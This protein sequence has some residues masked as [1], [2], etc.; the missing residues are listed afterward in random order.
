[1]LVCGPYDHREFREAVNLLRQRSR[2]TLCRD[3]QTAAAVLRVGFAPELLVVVVSHPGQWSSD[4]IDRLRRLCPLAPVVVL[5][6]S[7][8]E[9]ETRS[10]TP[11]PGVVR[12]YWH[13]AASQ[14]DRQLA[15]M[16]ENQRTPWSL[17]STS[18][19]DERLLAD[20]PY[21][22]A[23]A[24]AGCIPASAGSRA[25]PLLV[26]CSENRP[27]AEWLV[28]AAGRG[29]FACVTVS[30]RQPWSACGASPVLCDFDEIGTAEE[31]MLLGMVTSVHPAPVIAMMP[32][33]RIDQV[34]R[35]RTL[36]VA[37]V[38]GKPIDLRDLI[39]RLRGYAS[40]TSYSGSSTRTIS[41]CQP[42]S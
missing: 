29:G 42:G 5:L 37:D 35:L 17:P 22:P 31:A 10:G 30:R 26:I 23:A 19:P 24:D 25:R 7:W 13:E 3:P 28:D 16:R 12:L 40:S 33:P 39:W 20:L 14:L 6:G 9:G 34:G 11:W 18:A 36:G 27:M 15:A 1:M 4:E 32:F 8:C 41:R 21:I 38:L 2:A